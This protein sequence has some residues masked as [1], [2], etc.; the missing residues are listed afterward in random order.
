ME[1]TQSNVTIAH[2]S[3][4]AEGVDT[5]RFSRI[6]AFLGAG[7]VKQLMSLSVVVCGLDGLG[8]EIAKNL[9]LSGVGA[10]TL[11]DTKHVSWSDLSSHVRRI[12]LFPQQE[13]YF[14]FILKLVLSFRSRY[15]K[16]PCSELCGAAP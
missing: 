14:I 7:T 1:E 4:D 9:I 13:T 5:D 12:I 15:R 3:T 16:E 2:E 11:H 10:V 8:A 6:I